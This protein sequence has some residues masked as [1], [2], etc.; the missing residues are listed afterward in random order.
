MR[1]PILQGHGNCGSAYC[2]T[3]TSVETRDGY[4]TDGSAARQAGPSDGATARS[5]A[6]KSAAWSRHSPA[7]ARAG[8][9][10]PASARNAGPDAGGIADTG[11]PGSARPT[12]CNR[13]AQVATRE[14]AGV[15][16]ECDMNSGRFSSGA[17]TNKS[18]FAADR[19]HITAVSLSVD[20]ATVTIGQQARARCRNFCWDKERLS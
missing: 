17:P 5:T 9:A 1:F 20:H 7:S 19:R 11:S 18:S 15:A 3:L 14:A 13:C 2:H 8:R 16:A 6:W 4:S 10:T 12:T